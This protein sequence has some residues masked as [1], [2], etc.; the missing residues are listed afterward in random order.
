MAD[1]FPILVQKY[2]GRTI[3]TCTTVQKPCKNRANIVQKPYKIMTPYRRE[4]NWKTHR[5]KFAVTGNF[6]WEEEFV[7]D[8]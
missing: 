5:L 2:E 3:C 4:K 7:L 6:E 1:Y 8:P